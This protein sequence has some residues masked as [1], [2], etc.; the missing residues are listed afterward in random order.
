M[1]RSTREFHVGPSSVRWDGDALLIDIDEISV[2]LPSRVR[3]QVRVHPQALCTFS[4]GLDAAAQHRWGPIAPCARV[5]VD[6]HSPASQW[7]G[8]GY[9]DSN[10]GDE[11]VDR[12]F[13]EWDW[14]RGVLADG[15]R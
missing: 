5:E 11:P 9:V 10:E 2:P 1:Q 7:S 14:S 4:T 12:A 8:H 3:G 6:L 13:R 15:P